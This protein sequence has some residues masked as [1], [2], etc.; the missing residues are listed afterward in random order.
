MEV[1]LRD[2]PLAAVPFEEK[3]DHYESSIDWMVCSRTED[4]FV[5]RGAPG[6]LEDIVLAFLA[7]A[8][9]HPKEG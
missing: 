9:R 6:R 4:Y 2:T 5:G 3:K 1:D 7:W 8:E